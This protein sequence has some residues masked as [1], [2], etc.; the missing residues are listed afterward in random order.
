MICQIG[1]EDVGKL[2]MC[3]GGVVFEKLGDGGDGSACKAA[4]DQELVVAHVRVEVER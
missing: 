3:G 4:G 2:I 1:K